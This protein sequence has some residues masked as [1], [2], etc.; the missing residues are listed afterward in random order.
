MIYRYMKL[1]YQ[2]FFLSTEFLHFETFL[3]GIKNKTDK[4]KNIMSTVDINRMLSLVIILNR[5]F[6]GYS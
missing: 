6:L 4:Y 3:V 2:S 5:L 1:V